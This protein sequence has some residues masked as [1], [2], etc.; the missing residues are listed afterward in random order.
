M[1]GS[2][3]L[4]RDNA[5]RSFLT[6]TLTRRDTR[7]S[8]SDDT[9]ASGVSK[10]PLGLTTL[11][12]PPGDSVVADLIFVH[13]LNG[14]SQSTWSK[15]NDPSLFWPQEWLPRDEAFRDVRIH[16]FGYAS[17]V[18]RES[19][20]GLRDFA[21]SLLGAIKDCPAM[22]R[23]EKPSLI[24]VAHSMGGLVVK[25]AFVIGQ[26][27][28][29]FHST[30]QRVQAIFFLAT[31]HQGAAIAQ[32]LDRL[33]NLVSG[34]RPF[35]GQIMPHSQALQAINEDFPRASGGLHLVSFYE[36][37]PMKVLKSLVVEKHCAVM[38]AHNERTEALN[39]DHRNVAMYSSP[40]DRNYLT[41]RNALATYISPQRKTVESRLQTLALEVQTGLNTFLGITDAPE[42]EIGNLDLVRLSG[43][44]T[45]LATKQKYR[46]WR[47]GRDTRLLWFQ[48]RPGAGKT[49]LSSY[50]VDDLR[51]SGI[52]CC[53]FFF[54]SQDSAKSTTNAFLRSMAWQMAMLHPEIRLKLQEASRDW[55]GSPVD[56]IDQNAVWRRVFLLTL[57]KVRLSRPQYWVID[58]MDECKMNS[59][60]LSILTR[61]QEEWPMSIVVTSRISSE[62]YL[63]TIANP[64]ADVVG[65][66][67]SDEDSVRDISLFVQSNLK[68]L[69]F[70]PSAAWS[71]RL[72]MADYI[73]KKSAGCFLWAYLIC[74]ELR[75]TSQLEEIKRVLESTPS[76]MD[77]LY[78]RILLSMEQ[79]TFGK[80]SAKSI[81]VWATYSFRPLSTDEMH[82]AVE[83]DINDK[84][85]RV[86]RLISRSCSNL[87]YVDRY[88]KVQLIHMTAREFLGRKDA[89]KGSEFTSEFMVDKADGHRRIAK[90]CL[91]YLIQSSKVAPRARRLLSDP[92][93]ASQGSP[94]TARAFTDYAS[95]FLFQHLNLIKSTD[96]EMF[97]TLSKFL[98]SNSVLLWIEYISA[99]GEL[100]TVYQAGKIINALLTR[101]ARHSP[102]MR[103]AQKQLAL[104]EN[105]GND[106]IHIVTKFSRSLRASP[107][108]IHHLI[109]PF[110]PPDSAIRQQ[111][112][113]PYRGLSVQGLSSRRWDHCLTTIAYPKGTKPNAVAAGPGFF[114][115]GMMS[116]SV[117]VYD[118]SIFQEVHILDHKEPVWQMAFGETGKH[119][120]TAG[121]KT[122]RIWSL[123]LGIELASFRIPSLCLALTFTETDEALRVA[124]KSN[125]FLE[126]D[127][128]TASMRAE[129]DWTTDFE[130][131]S[132]LQLRAPQMAAISGPS[133][134]LAV[135]YRGEDIVIWDCA[136]IRIHDIY[137][138]ETGSRRWGSEKVAGGSTHI[139][140]LVF[141][142]AIDTNRLATTHTDGDLTLYDTVD[143]KLLAKASSVNANVLAS[144]HDGRTL[145]GVDSRGNL[146]LFDFETLRC[147]YR[148]QFDTPS[149]AKALT[150]TADNLRCIEIRGDQCRV[151]EPTV[152]LRQDTADEDENSDTVSVSTGPQEIDYRVAG[153]N[154]DGAAAKITAV[155]CAKSAPLV[156][157]GME[158]GSVHVCD[159]TA[160]PRSQR[161]YEQIAGCP[162]D[163]LYFDEEASVLGCADLSGCVTA[164][165]VTRR[166]NPRQRP[167]GATWE[168]GDILLHTRIP[169]TVKQILLSGKDKKLLLSSEQHD[170]LWPMPKQGEGVWIARVE[171][172]STPRWLAHPTQPYLILAREGEFRIYN[173]SNLECVRTVSLA[174]HG[175]SLFSLDRI[176]SLQHPQYFTTISLA[177]S[178][179]SWT[180]ES[181]V[182]LW[183]VK[184]LDLDLD[185]DPTSSLSETTSSP[186]T[187][188]PVRDLGPDDLSGTLEL[189]VGAYGSRLIVYT[190]DR[191]VCS[192][193]LKPA[194]ASAPAFPFPSRSAS[195]S[196]SPRSRSPSPSPGSDQ[197]QHQLV[198]HFFVP[199]DWIGGNRLGMGVGRGG[200]IAF[201]RGPELAVIK[202]GLEVTEG[203]ESFNP[204]K[205]IG[206]PVA[207][208]A[209][210]GPSLG[211]SPGIPVRP[212]VGGSV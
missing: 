157:Y 53:F 44:C 23:D 43:S 67:I 137:E 161:L 68:Y 11:Y 15:G 84:I 69:P 164:R 163:L 34:S 30:V 48:G 169:G 26:Q 186:N 119:L 46:A 64:R 162:L 36:S 150:F 142:G 145:G 206:A 22:D 99:R 120:A 27:H 166:N 104:L 127:V 194:S 51:K 117:F 125:M 107:S 77:D 42:D 106:L 82:E 16:T 109:P 56:K 63:S 59:D 101:R 24:F 177:R 176:V 160:E 178:L 144:S 41:V 73:V 181:L 32:T 173:W 19:I 193:D 139:R 66:T 1:D 28:P 74:M 135:I 7:A 187:I 141:S 128:E 29:E 72:E 2:R 174:H 175:Q 18:N 149:M 37:L 131:D 97:I 204:R 190:S 88:D 143:G 134:L 45:W 81:L 91:E 12:D 61:I 183:D 153:S 211:Q 49:V 13:G 111:F 133:D 54:S 89:N 85:D 132:P 21:K 196:R 185:L 118:D 10:G 4:N 83:V 121:A 123:Q 52:D 110:C 172:N 148:V 65:D 114:A 154:S 70:P 100:H 105:W 155:A 103:F 3:D 208:G 79:A 75:K 55:Q 126:W 93:L 76:T 113:S 33:L 116:K 188:S 40:E 167:L 95:K 20:L 87:V 199:G 205:G 115:I 71:S 47:D 209:G 39:A 165:K 184:D 60:M 94:A 57:L 102:P 195:R 5:A 38:N 201:V 112:S 182:Q 92:D 62:A 31:P 124:T 191:W 170:T 151:W 158:D 14:G 108:C 192:V 203:G 180:T 86:D 171:G 80:D 35:I 212:R 96:T 140:A 136:N 152:L 9:V 50:I 159:I 6:R 147:L 78:K 198:R 207:G 122:V 197:H 138:K 25:N 200:E 156:F 130:D 129:E 90:V 189:V 210:A 202:R 17:G 146:M 58:A 168:I 98:S 179:E 8:V